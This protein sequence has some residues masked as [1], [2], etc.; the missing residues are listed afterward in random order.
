M[1][2]KESHTYLQ[3][4]CSPNLPNPDNMLEDDHEQHQ[5]R[6]QLINYGHSQWGFNNWSWSVTKQELGLF[7]FLTN[8]LN[9]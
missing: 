2:V 7:E 6:Q 8:L 9:E 4:D 1:N 5:R 3:P